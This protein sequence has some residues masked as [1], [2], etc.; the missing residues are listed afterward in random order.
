MSPEVHLPPPFT[1]LESGTAVFVVGLQNGDEGKGKISE[2]IALYAAAVARGNGGSNAGHRLVKKNPDINEDEFISL[3]QI[4]CGLPYPTKLN[5]ISPG[6]LVDPVRL[7]EEIA[8]AKQIGFDVSPANL[9]ISGIA[10]MVVPKHK[11]LETYHESGAGAQG[12]TKA[13]IRFAEADRS[14]RTGLR[15][16]SLLTKSRKELAQIAYEGLRAEKTRLG[17]FGIRE[18]PM[19]RR[20]AKRLATEFANSAKRMVPYLQDTPA[21][22]NGM[23]A[24]G[25]IVLVEGA[26]A[27]GLD[28]NYGKY[29]FNTSSGTTVAALLEGTGIN[30]NYMGKKI[31]VFKA[32]PSKVGGGAFVSK[33]T[34]EKLAE[35][36]R[37]KKGEVDSEYGGTTGREREVG[38]LDLFSLKVAIQANGIDELAVTKFDCI[39]RQGEKFKV[40]IGY[41]QEYV[42]AKGEKQYKVLET[43]PTSNE[44]LIK[45]QPIFSQEMPTWKDDHSKDAKDFLN[46]AEQYLGKPISIVS[47]GPSRDDVFF[48]HLQKLAA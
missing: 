21:I 4:P 24:R 25:E 2:L 15:T 33:I 27:F 46:F 41:K 1:E 29:P 37:G 17:F 28:K 34:D 40:V 8:E 43:A 32:T 35:R 30:P 5:V 42:D 48:P 19:K 38:Y 3:H 31:G 20:D 14:L 16:E 9:A 45:C 26:Q 12:S 18:L 13:G 36:I 6:S 7:Q 23:L 22:L 39:A 44:D 11:A 47:N 10:Q